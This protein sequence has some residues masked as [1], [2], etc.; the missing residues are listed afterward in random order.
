MFSGLPSAERS[1]QLYRRS[2]HRKG[3]RTNLVD[4][5]PL[6]CSPNKTGEVPLDILNIVELGGQGVVDIND[7]DLPVGLSFIEKSHDTEN[8]DLLDLTYIS[9]LLANLAH[10]KRVIVAVSLGLRMNLSRV[11]PSLQTCISF[12]AT[13]SACTEEKILEVVRK[14]VRT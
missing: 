6:V 5:E 12:T 8:F 1:G 14:C 11:F 4:P 13:R 7:D 10:V 3:T 9:K 2:R